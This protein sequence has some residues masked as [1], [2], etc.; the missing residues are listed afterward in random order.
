MSLGSRLEVYNFLPAGRRSVRF[1]DRKVCLRCCQQPFPRSSL[2]V[3]VVMATRSNGWPRRLSTWNSLHPERL[4]AACSDDIRQGTD[5][6]VWRRFTPTAMPVTTTFLGELQQ[7]VSL[8]GYWVVGLIVG[9][10]TAS[11]LRDVEAIA[12]FSPST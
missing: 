8:H 12:T 7:L 2:S 5:L 11:T 3:S 4:S 6:Y 10:T 1:K 9:T